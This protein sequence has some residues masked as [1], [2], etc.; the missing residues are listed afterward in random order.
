MLR[1]PAYDLSPADEEACQ[2]AL[3]VKTAALLPEALPR[4]VFLRWLAEQGFLLH[5]SP[6]VG[7]ETFEPRTP[8]D[9]SGD[10]FSSRTGVFATSDAL[11]ALMYALR[12]PA[13]TRM[14]NMAL[15][16]KGAD[17]P[18]YFLSFATDDG[19]VHSGRHLLAPGF[20]YVL[21]RTGF[22][23]MP[24]YNWPGLGMVQEPQW[25]SPSPVRPL[26][27]V[28]VQPAD[29]PLPVRLHDRATVDAR[30]RADPWGF[31]WLTAHPGW[32]RKNDL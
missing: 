20:V 22:E 4:W 17:G 3:G 13:V 10:E 9:L 23:P 11:W 25:V 26:F 5:G 29:F 12:G 7:I 30:C 15:T 8:H 32:M 6:R 18:R 2:A 1:A 28:P 16:V 19:A 24:A 21:L 27:T 14:V 31:P